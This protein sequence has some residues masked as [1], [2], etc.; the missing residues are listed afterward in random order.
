MTSPI[1]MYICGDDRLWHAVGQPPIGPPPPPAA[2]RVI[3]V[4]SV[5]VGTAPP[6]PPPGTY[7]PTVFPFGAVETYEPGPTTTGIP[8]GTTLTTLVPSTVGTLDAATGIITITANNVVI[9]SKFVPYYLKIQGNNCRITRSEIVGSPITW[10][11]TESA[12]IDHR[13]VTQTGL[14]VADC[15]IHPQVPNYYINGFIGHHATADRNEIYHVVDGFGIYNNNAGTSPV[16]GEVWKND[17]DLT[18][19]ANWL[20]DFAFFFPDPAHADG[21]HNDGIQFH[22][23]KR[24]QI[25]GNRFDW[26]AASADQFT[27]PAQNLAIQGA[28][29]F[30]AQQGGTDATATANRGYGSG[31]FI[32][33][34]V[35]HITGNTI[36]GNWM[37]GTGGQTVIRT[38]GPNYVGQNRYDLTGKSYTT[39]GSRYEIRTNDS[40]VTSG[41]ITGLFTNVWNDTGLPLTYDSAN[42]ANGRGGIRTDPG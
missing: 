37:H 27:A 4:S 8:T 6:P 23:G 1:Q 30:V 35:S 40:M 38:T 33:D 13:F 20:H 18:A 14:F 21:T 11:G 15:L 10:A 34:I 25:L 39:S 24:S 26:F 16:T 5:N 29:A 9:D 3:R 2:G 42:P 7:D 17:G 41:A 28:N 36:R 12:L 19:R 22:G 32:N 31:F